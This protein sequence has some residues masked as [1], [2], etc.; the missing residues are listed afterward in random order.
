MKTYN[1]LLNEFNTL[2]YNKEVIDIYKEFS[3]LELMEVYI[4]NKLYLKEY[5]DIE[6]NEILLES[7]IN[8]IQSVLNTLGE[9]IFDFIM[10]ILKLLKDGLNTLINWVDKN[11]NNNVKFSN[12]Q[13]DMNAFLQEYNIAKKKINTL[14]FISDTKLKKVVQDG[15]V[16]I[17]YNVDSKNNILDFFKE[18]LDPNNS[19]NISTKWSSY[20][21]LMKNLCDKEYLINFYID[22]KPNKTSNTFLCMDINKFIELCKY[23]NKK[24]LL[25]SLSDRDII[26]VCGDLGCTEYKKDNNR[27]FI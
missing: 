7:V 2:P 12:S 17:L 27:D 15:F 10:K 24:A 21:N 11:F 9:K 22:T 16:K 1:D 26:K 8:N 18:D 25:S 4:S 5:Q 6:C 3:E 20:Y 19:N 13:Y 23:I 14:S